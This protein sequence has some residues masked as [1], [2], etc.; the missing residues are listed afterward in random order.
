MGGFVKLI[1]LHILKSGVEIKQRPGE[2]RVIPVP[3]QD[4]SDGTLDVAK[5]GPNSDLLG[6]DVR[7]LAFEAGHRQ[8]GSQG[9][10]D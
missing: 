1:I 8:V 10:Q 6:Y 2:D 7:K 4:W 5:N 3:Q 9:Y